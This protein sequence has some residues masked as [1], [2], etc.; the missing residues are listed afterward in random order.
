[1]SEANDPATDASTVQRMLGAV[2]RLV[3]ENR[4]LAVALKALIRAASEVVS[5]LDSR[6]AG[7]ADLG[8][9][10]DGTEWEPLRFHIMETLKQRNVSRVVFA[11][12]MGVQLQMLG[13]WLVPGNPGPPAATRDKFRAWCDGVASVAPEGAVNPLAAIVAVDPRHG[14]HRAAQPSRRPRRAGRTA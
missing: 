5:E 4:Q 1:M 11:K 7:P 9:A 2:V 12:Q 3:P 10:P 13:S 14:Q 6:A 8:P